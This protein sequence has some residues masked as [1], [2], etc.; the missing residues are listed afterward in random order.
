MNVVHMPL[1]LTLRVSWRERDQHTGRIAND[2]DLRVFG[3]SAVVWLRY[4]QIPERPAELYQSSRTYLLRGD[5]QYPVALQGFLEHLR[6][7]LKFL[8]QERRVLIG[9]GGKPKKECTVE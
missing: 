8:F 3:V 6:Q 1:E 5:H 9:N 4:F 2:K 7:G